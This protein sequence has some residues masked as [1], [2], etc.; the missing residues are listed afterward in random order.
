MSIRVAR[1]LIATF[2]ALVGCLGLGIIAPSAAAVARTDA[3]PT[4][5]ITPG[6][7]M[8]TDVDATTT[9]ACTAA[10]VFRNERATFLGYAAHCAIP[11]QPKHETGCE[12]DTLPLGTHVTIHGLRGGQ[13]DGRL[14]YSA[15]RTMR[16]VGETDDDRCRYNDFALVEIDPSDIASLDPTVPE[17]GGPT[18]LEAAPPAQF[19]QVVSYQP[20]VTQPALKQ[21]VTLGRRGGG[22]SHR[23]DIA[24]SASFGDSGSGLLD[25]RGAAFG[26]L[27]TRYLDQLASSGVTDLRLAMAYAQRFGGIDDLRLVPGTLPF[28]PASGDLCHGGAAPRAPAAA[29]QDGPCPVVDVARR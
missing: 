24:P 15:W 28:R 11:T 8:I 2:C 14:A 26:I 29:P 25:A 22:W 3:P 18:G 13:A 9:T 1:R 19:E 17:V 5:M 23:I 10:F 16:E 4:E 7:L 20:Y 12:Y 27:V 6:S 21:G